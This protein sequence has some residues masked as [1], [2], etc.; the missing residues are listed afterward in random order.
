M[1]IKPAGK[2]IRALLKSGRQFTIPRF[3][4]D[5]S[6]E[7]KNSEEFL[8]DIIKGLSCKNGKIETSS[9]FLGTML[10]I[11]NYDEKNDKEIQVVD[12][13]QRITP[14]TILFSA[15]SD[16]F[17]EK[18]EDKLS[19]LIFSYIMTNDDDG[20]PVRI[21]KSESSYP[22]FSYYIQD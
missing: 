13:L 18:G 10:F 22:F 5:Y 14:I 1:N 19:E 3:Q 2:T 17:R 9:Y 7:K 4:R 11:G 15:I 20:N 6:W 16:I 12:G 8:D 21:I